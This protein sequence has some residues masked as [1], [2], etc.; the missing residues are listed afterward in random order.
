MTL[1]PITGNTY[2]VRAKIHELGGTWDPQR[3]AWMVPEHNAAKASELVANAP[4]ERSHT[5][6]HHKC[7]VCG[8]TASRHVKIYRS[9]ECRDCYEE[10]K[11]GY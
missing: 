4:Q 6:T 8:A 5:F 9:G 3:K 11:M 2:P 7:V 1:I 10:R